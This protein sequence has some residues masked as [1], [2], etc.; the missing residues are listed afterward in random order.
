MTIYEEFR[1]RFWLPRADRRTIRMT[2][3]KTNVCQV[4]HASPVHPV[5]SGTVHAADHCSLR[6]AATTVVCALLSVGLLATPIT[7]E[8]LPPPSRV[9][10]E[11]PMIAR[12]IVQA[13]EASP[14]VRREIAA[15]TEANGLVYVHEGYCRHGVLACLAMTVGRAGSWR[16]LR[17]KLDLRRPDLDTMVAIGHELHHASEALGDAGVT[18]N[19][20]I[21]RFFRQ[22][23]ET[24]DSGRFETSAARRAGDAVYQ[25]V[26]AWAKDR[27]TQRQ[28]SA[29]PYAQVRSAIPEPERH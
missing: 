6:P 8:T 3:G 10:S 24:G 5:G 13:T 29:S 27:A 17:I 23:G 1:R 16:L 18:N 11:H 26:R 15:I 22:L 4:I 7:G 21:V 20:Q 14:T 9:R 2:S 12:L 28:L 19:V 25:E